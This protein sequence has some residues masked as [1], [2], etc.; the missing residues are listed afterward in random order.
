MSVPDHYAG[1]RVRCPG[2]QAAL[3]V[4]MSE[5]TSAPGEMSLA[6]QPVV[7]LSGLDDNQA[8]GV[9][10]LRQVLI[11][12]GVCQKTI[13]V[14]ESKLGKTAACT[15][16]GVVLKVDAFNLAKA[17]GDLIDMT[18]LEL[19]KADL[20]LDGGSHGS[21]LGGSSIQLD[22]SAAGG[23]G[24]YELN[25]PP[26]G[27]MS[28]VS[29][30][31]SQS[32]MREL[33]ELN[34]L[35]HSG[36]ISSQEY[37]ER[38]KEIYA[39]KSLAIQAM[40]RSADGSGNRPVIKRD[41]KAPLLPKPVVFLI[42]IAILGGG[43]FAAWS[44]LSGGSSSPS[45]VAT[46]PTTPGPTDDAAGAG[47]ESSSEDTA[48]A[49]TLAGTEDATA[50]ATTVDPPDGEGDATELIST[51]EFP[52]TMF[53]I[54]D[55]LGT[56]GVQPNNESDEPAVEMTIT[57][58][59]TEWPTYTVDRGDDRAIGKAC[60]LLQRVTVRDDRALIG[61][62][63]GPAA[64]DLDS[65]VYQGFRQ[66]MHDILIQGAE[67]DGVLEDLNLRTSERTA[68]LGPLESHRLHITS[69]SDRTVRAT[70]LTGIQDGY[71]VTYWFAGSKTLYDEFLDTVG[72]AEF[73]PVR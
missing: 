20:L 39:G 36:Q 42:V 16:C 3:R 24:G 14:P 12:C 33:R 37:R 50:A 40:S 44:A 32:Q 2:C 52:V 18:H 34:D 69:K 51:A 57:A 28:G 71:C 17:K 65:P 15:S 56:I 53:E 21:T 22:G 41:D 13:K 62:A 73:G 27:S 31:N 9:R 29:V 8:S 30:N 46:T 45:N 60:Q 35:K 6:S 64:A 61:V 5:P 7:D 25:M 4:P 68:K 47:A 19:E 66:E 26:A 70:I 38:K 55:S 59:P 72:Q 23:T 10:R 54:E 43:G 48:A 1:K 63:V 49:D 11:G 58:W 67:A